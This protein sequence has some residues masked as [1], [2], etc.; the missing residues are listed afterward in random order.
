[1]ISAASLAKLLCKLSSELSHTCPDRG[2]LP[3]VCNCALSYLWSLVWCE[4]HSQMCV[5]SVCPESQMERGAWLPCWGASS[6]YR[7]QICQMTG[8]QTLHTLICCSCSTSKFLLEIIFYLKWTISSQILNILVGIKVSYTVY[9]AIL[10]LYIIK[11]L[12]KILIRRPNSQII[13]YYIFLLF[14]L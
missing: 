4:R 14:Y 1:M 2:R 11:V 5:P 10:R 12:Y 6:P 8:Q 7:A 3:T 13:Y 9:W